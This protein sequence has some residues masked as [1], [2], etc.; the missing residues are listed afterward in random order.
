MTVAAAV[1]IVVTV[2]VTIATV[3]AVLTAVTRVLVGRVPISS[4]E[5]GI[6]DRLS[7]IE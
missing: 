6:V 5:T 4:W 2:A 3:A 1:T 7:E